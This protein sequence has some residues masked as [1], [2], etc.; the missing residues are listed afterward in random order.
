MSRLHATDAC[1]NYPQS[2][3]CVTRRHTAPPTLCANIIIP[4]NG[5]Q[6]AC[7]VFVCSGARARASVCADIAWGGCTNV[8]S[9]GAL[10][11][12]SHYVLGEWKPIP[13]VPD[14]GVDVEMKQFANL[15]TWHHSVCSIDSHNPASHRIECD[16]STVA[17][18]WSALVR[19][20]DNA[21]NNDNE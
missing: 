2:Q 20:P 9:V 4:G 14:G 17:L 7:I 16:T 6:F 12:I 3:F 19:L 5:A 1:A 13:L 21:N 15:Y 18:L 11:Y 8:C 10:A